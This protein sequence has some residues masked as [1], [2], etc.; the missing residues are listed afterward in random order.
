MTI[1][2]HVVVRGA[3]NAAAWYHDVFGAVE[4]ERVPAAGGTYMSIELWFG[5]A[6]IRL[7]DEFPEMQVLSPASVGGTSIT[8]QLAV[9]DVDA[10]WQRAV[11]AGASSVHAP[12]DA[13]WGDRH[14][15]VVDPFGHRWGLAKHL[16]DVP[17]DDVV[18]AAA[19]L[20]APAER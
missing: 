4:R 8:L 19:A 13:F 1:T 10:T 3:A 15:I 16:R 12:A 11:A 17:H 2:P 5:D 6:S 20:F 18:R 9:D 7:A 14:A